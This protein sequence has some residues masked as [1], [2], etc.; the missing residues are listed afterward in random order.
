ME[1]SPHGEARRIGKDWQP[2]A[3]SLLS[4]WAL[5]L[6]YRVG[7]AT[8][9]GKL[10]DLRDPAL[11][12]ALSF[13]FMVSV[14]LCLLLRLF[15]RR[16]LA[17]GLALAALLSLPAAGLGAS[18][19]MA[20]FFR[21]SPAVNQPSSPQAPAGREVQALRERLL[22]QAPLLT[23]RNATG[24]YFFYFCLGS[25]FAGLAS[26]ERLRTAERAAAAFQRAAQEAQLRA[27]R[28]QVNPHFLFN[29]LNSL[30]AL[31]MTQRVE[32]AE[33]MIL[34]MSAFL[35]STLALDPTA[36]IT[37]REEM[38][39]QRLYL[40]IEQ[41]RFPDRLR[42]AID[43]PD[44]LLDCLVPAL[45]LQPLVENA[46]K[47]GVARSKDPVAVLIAARAEG[48]V[49]TLTVENDCPVVWTDRNEGV[50][51]GVGLINVGERLAARF[52]AAADCASALRE[53]GTFR[54][55]LRMPM[56]QS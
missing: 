31:V 54:V 4:V 8:L 16:G 20:L 39:L 35:R 22:R 6:T 41:G 14:V 51:V 32:E 38:A 43:I 10:A 17:L 56:V 24:W 42:V 37:L 34:N 52:G 9:D 15:I 48:E 12:A 47:H 44:A 18:V 55:V 3:V 30:S 2:L 50:G 49:L 19:E 1:L 33:R 27:L 29:T 53:D 7:L 13:G 26:A 5:H 28:Y 23:A 46:V 45:I 21:L 11:L 25:L 40:D 36:D